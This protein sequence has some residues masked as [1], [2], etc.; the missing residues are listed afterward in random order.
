MEVGVECRVGREEPSAGA[1]GLPSVRW[2]EV[3]S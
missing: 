3:L 1:H 2:Q